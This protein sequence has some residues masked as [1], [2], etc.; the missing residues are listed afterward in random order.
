M[1]ATMPE[2]VSDLAAETEVIER[3]LA[4]LSAN[5]WDTPTPAEGW[6]IRD[7]IAHL[8]YFDEAA[9]AA[10]VDPV[11][12]SAGVGVTGP[13]SVPGRQRAASPSPPTAPR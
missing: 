3:M 7:Q 11:R 8:A 2:L 13:R 4:G 12:F 9:L 5:A 10:V 1:A 6:L